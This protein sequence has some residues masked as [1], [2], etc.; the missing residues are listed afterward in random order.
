MR[1]V[2]W[3]LVGVGVGATLGLVLAPAPGQ[4]MREALSDAAAGAVEVAEA[5]MG[6]VAQKAKAVVGKAKKTAAKS[7]KV[8]SGPTEG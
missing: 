4:E 7:E 8:V 3:F 5:R 6:D 1:G 2:L